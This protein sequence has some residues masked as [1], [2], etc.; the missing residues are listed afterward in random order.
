MKIKEKNIS[1]ILWLT[2]III[3]TIIVFLTSCA[4][5]K[6]GIHR[7]EIMHTQIKY[8][9][10]DSIKQNHFVN[11]YLSYPLW[12]DTYFILQGTDTICQAGDTIKKTNSIEQSLI[13]K[14]IKPTQS[15]R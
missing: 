12:T 10:C 7:S 8:L 15:L 14:K 4:G 13:W 1:K 2:L 11:H 6:T 3:V 5:I 9:K